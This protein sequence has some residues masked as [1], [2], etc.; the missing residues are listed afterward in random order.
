MSFE[1]QNL[2]EFALETN[3]LHT[4]AAQNPPGITNNFSASVIKETSQSQEKSFQTL[5]PVADV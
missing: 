5:H 2:I 1:I 4:Y 3:K